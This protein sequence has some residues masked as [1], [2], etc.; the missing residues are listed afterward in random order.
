MHSL[1]MLLRSPRPAPVTGNSFSI[2]G[3]QQLQSSLPAYAI[4]ARIGTGCCLAI[5]SRLGYRPAVVAF[6]FNDGR[7]SGLEI[8]YQDR[9]DDFAAAGLRGQQQKSFDIGPHELDRERP[10]DQLFHVIVRVIIVEI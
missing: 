4:K 8:V 7:M 2:E 5:G 3:S 9:I 1:S 10:K 6:Y